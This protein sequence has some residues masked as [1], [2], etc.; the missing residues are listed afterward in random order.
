MSQLR[1]K[2]KAARRQQ[3]LTAAEALFRQHG[4]NAV[5]VEQIAAYAEVAPATVYNYYGS[6]GEVLLALVAQSDG[7]VVRLGETLQQRAAEQPFQEALC[8][9]LIQ[10]NANSLKQLD[11]TT[12]RQVM[13]SDM[14]QAASTNDDRSLLS[15]NRRFQHQIQRLIECHRDS[16]HLSRGFD[17]P[18]AA[19][20]FHNLNH[21]L[22]LRLIMKDD[23]S[24]ADYQHILT[25]QVSW[26]LST[27]ESCVHHSSP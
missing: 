6:K 26:I 16:G 19:E 4:F 24:L 7:D 3:I 9:L 11:K 1:A 10:F 12:W 13:S 14:L 20:V 21:A 5:T 18:L 23:L 2:Q 8:E 25:R 15:L 22:F 17:I 27:T